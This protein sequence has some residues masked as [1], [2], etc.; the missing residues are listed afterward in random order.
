MPSMPVA[1]PTKISSPPFKPSFPTSPLPS[2]SLRLI[3]AFT[4][5]SFPSLPNPN[6]NPNINGTSNSIANAKPPLESRRRPLPESKTLPR[7]HQK[8]SP[9]PLP[10][11]RDRSYADHDGSGGDRLS[12]VRTMVA[13]CLLELVPFTEIDSAALLRRLESDQSSASPAE[14][15]A[16]VELGGE[17]GAISAVEMALH[18][19]ADDGGGVQLDNFTVNGKSMLMVWGIDR[20]KLLK[21]LPESS[22]QQ[23]L[24]PLESGSVDG[25]SQSQAMLLS[26]SD[27]NAAMMQRPPHELWMGHPDHHLSGLP[28]IYPGARA[29]GPMIGPRGGP[30]MIGM[31]AIPGVIGVPPLPRPL[32][33]PVAALAGPTPLPAKPRTEED[34]RKDIEALLNK[35][36]F[37]EK[38]KSKTGEELFDLIHRPTAKGN[39]SCC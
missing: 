6:S 12:I 10:S 27:R 20:S 37:R 21:E 24:L 38:Q 33:G 23:Q 15:A 35:K 13:V 9:I 30:R 8:T 39:C 11:N 36:T 3:S 14:K 34:D 26:A 2:I 1:S 18:H 7:K 25:N 17:L 19:I 4:G 28:S 16:M 22:Y 5:R 32:L 29:P 31:M